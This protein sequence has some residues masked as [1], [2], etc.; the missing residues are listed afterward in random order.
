MTVLRSAHV[1]GTILRVERF[2]ADALKKRSDPRPRADDVLLATP[3]TT[4]APATDGLD[5]VIATDA[6]VDDPRRMHRDAFLERLHAMA[7]ATALDMLGERARDC[8]YIDAWFARHANTDAATLERLAR[9]YAGISGGTTAEALIEMLQLRLRMGIA[10]WRSGEDL[11]GEAELAGLPATASALE[12]PCTCG[13][14]CA[15]CQ[16]AAATP[17]PA[18][19][20]AEIGN[21][22]GI[23]SHAPTAALAKV[24]ETS[25]RLGAAGPLDS[26][27]RTRMERAFGR[28]FANVG[29]HT[30][31]QATALTSEHSARAVTV[32]QHIAF[33]PGTY[34]PGTLI[35]DLLIAHELAHTTQQ[36]G[37]SDD[38]RGN[39]HGLENEADRAAVTAMLGG[40]AGSIV[41][42]TGLRL[43]RCAAA[44]VP[45][46][47]AGAGIGFGWLATVLGAAGLAGIL[48][49]ESD[50]PK[51]KDEDDPCMPPLVACLENKWQPDWNV[52]DFGKVKDCSACY[53]ECKHAGGAW[54][55][56]KCPA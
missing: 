18:R 2:R 39:G 35:G 44:A 23:A 22:E 17:D 49:M 41:S 11:A 46:A 8:P 14:T 25:D 42:R 3:H 5:S 12:G 33:A 1:R 6:H 40:R 15:K 19:V 47:G 20:I 16:G 32:G 13:G 34:Q 37:A 43:Q 38:A 48:T 54:P 53:R 24:T 51:P 52:N 45:A 28:S 10:Y 26:S 30:G 9:R 4:R 31:H 27:V 29:I 55:Y 36:E 50:S 7:H 56:Y 21:G